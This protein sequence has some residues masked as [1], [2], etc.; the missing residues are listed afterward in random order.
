MSTKRKSISVTKEKIVEYWK[1][2]IDNVGAKIKP[3]WDIAENHCWICGSKSGNQRCHIIPDCLGGEPIPSNLILLCE[4]CHGINPETIYYDDYWLWF[5]VMSKDIYLFQKGM[6]EEEVLYQRMYGGDLI[7][8]VQQIG[9]MNFYEIIMKYTFDNRDKYLITS[10]A[11]KVIIVN[12]YF[13]QCLRENFKRDKIKVCKSI[14]LNII[15]PTVEIEEEKPVEKNFEN[16]FLNIETIEE[17]NI[18]LPIATDKKYWNLLRDVKI[19][20][21]F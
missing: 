4:S 13:E 7:R 6:L 9:N 5:K 10:M 1:N 17:S 15:T 12:K 11:T 16:N 20:N 18:I 3:S 19:K 2:N 21:G 8:L 14:K